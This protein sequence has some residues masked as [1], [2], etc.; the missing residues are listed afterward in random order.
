MAHSTITS[1]PRTPGCPKRMEFGPCGGVRDDLRSE[2]APHRC[3]FVDSPPRRWAS[4]VDVDVLGQP[5]LR[6]QRGPLFVLSDL[7][8]RPFDLQSVR[9]VTAVL[10]DAADGL[11]VGEHQSRPDFPPTLMAQMVTAV[12]GR[13]WLTLTCRDRNRVVLE[14]EAAGLRAAEVA[15]VLC[16]TGDG[17]GPGIRPDVSQVFDLDCTRLAALVARTGL[18]VAVAEAP[19]AAPRSHWPHRV[20]AKQRAGATICF[21]NHVGSTARLR[22]FV[23]QCRAIGVTL[24]FVAGVAVYTDERSAR[25]LQSF[26][27]L[28][29]PEDRVRAVLSAADPVRA[30]IDAAV[31]QARELG[32]VDGVV[33][34]NLSGLASAR[35]VVFA[36]EV[37]AEI[38]RTLRERAA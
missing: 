1:I 35:D 24:P 32:R 22:S 10:R 28:S 7:T 30:D 14:Q 4:D 2:M 31:E 6:A 15:G 26:P 3:V 23:E 5:A 21:L 13:P 34:V 38:G 25:V 18:T 12:G 11:L 27:G 37:K 19:D 33:G 20:L 8:V 29:L 16:V 9:R 17:R 36:A